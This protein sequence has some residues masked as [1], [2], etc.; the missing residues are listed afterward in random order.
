MKKLRF[1]K[2]S[3][4]RWYIDLAEWTGS[5]T[6]LEMVAGADTMLE[7]I[8]DGESQVLIMLSEQK[9]KNCDKLEFLR[10]ATEIE[11]G[12]FYKL[13]KYRGIRIGLEIWLCDVTKFV[14][15]NFPQILYLSTTN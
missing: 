6:D 12:A 9:F 8:A 1:Y 4:N 2:E 11:N 5:K 3:D 10:L 13:E 15:G 14:F 7:Y